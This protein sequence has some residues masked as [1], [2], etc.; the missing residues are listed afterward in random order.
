MNAVISAT[1]FNSGSS[2][3][4]PDIR[5]RRWDRG[6]LNLI[7]QLTV[8]FS[9]TFLFSFGLIRTGKPKEKEREMGKA[10]LRSISGL[11]VS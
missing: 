7:Q 10:I 3:S 8:A 1:K 2:A 9:L 11:Y 6:E 4:P 5:L